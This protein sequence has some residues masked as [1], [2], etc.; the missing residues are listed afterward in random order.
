VSPHLDNPARPIIIIGLI[1]RFLRTLTS[2]RRTELSLTEPTESSSVRYVWGSVRTMKP[3]PVSRDLRGHCLSHC[4]LHSSIHFYFSL[5]LRI[6][7]YFLFCYL[8]AD[9]VGVQAKSKFLCITP[10][11]RIF[12]LCI[13]VISRGLSPAHSYIKPSR[14]PLDNPNPPIYLP[15]HRQILRELPRAPEPPHP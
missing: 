15:P 14:S 3:A 6:I 12:S 10:N 4:L 9:G 2:V 13:A 8:D 5:S 7:I 1:P 11:F